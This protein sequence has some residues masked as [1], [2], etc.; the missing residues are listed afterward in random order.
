[1]TDEELLCGVRERAKGM[2]FSARF[3]VLELARRYETARLDIEMLKESYIAYEETTGLKQAK[4][5]AIKEFAERLKDEY[6]W[7]YNE[8]E[9]RV[10][11]TI[12]NLV[13]EMVGDAE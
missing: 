7:H 2:E 11:D 5:D 4:A 12:D 13:K 9:V 6:K 8:S 10:Y 3:C 1:M